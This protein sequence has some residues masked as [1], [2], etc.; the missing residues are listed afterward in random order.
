[1]NPQNELIQEE[2]TA[3]QEAKPNLRKKYRK[4]QLEKLGDLRTLTLGISGAPVDFS[5][6]QINQKT[7]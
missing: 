1:M 4:P 5:G 6:G 3:T 7:P 2:K